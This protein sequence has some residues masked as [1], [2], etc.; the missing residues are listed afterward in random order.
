[1]SSGMNLGSAEYLHIE[2]ERIRSAYAKRLKNDLR[3]S[4]SNPGHLFFIQQREKSFIRLLERNGCFF[5]ANRKILE[6]GCGNGSLM[7]EFVK[8]GALPENVTGVELLTDRVDEAISL[9][10]KGMQIIQGNTAKLSF[11]DQSFDIVLQSTVFT[12]VLE[13]RMKAQMAA[14]M[15]RVLKPDGLILWYDYHMDNPKNPDV[16]GITSREIRELFPECVIQLQRAT[17]APPIARLLA[18]Y[19]WILCYFLERVPWLCTHYVGVIRKSKL[20]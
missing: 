8:W 14:E 17:L 9:C 12:S 13:K 19:S 4:F 16:K 6:I 11:V 18:P 1:M 7:R 5:L 3:Y 20:R 15:C 10:P 2:E